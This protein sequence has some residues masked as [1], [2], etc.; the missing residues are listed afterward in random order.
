MTIAIVILLLVIIIAVLAIFVVL[1]ILGSLKSSSKN[2]DI[3]MSGGAD[4]KHGYVSYDNNFFKGLS[5]ELVKTTVLNQDMRSNNHY[6]RSLIL[7]NQ[8][9]SQHYN[10]TLEPDIVLGRLEV[11]GIFIV[12]D[13]SVSKEHCRIYFDGRDVYIED[14]HSTNHTFINETRVIASQ[15]LYTGDILRIGNTRFEIVL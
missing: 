6:G 2:I 14:L 5:G 11:D 15:K 13:A 1:I 12:Q 4:I 8:L 7:I 9:T 3:H 10:L